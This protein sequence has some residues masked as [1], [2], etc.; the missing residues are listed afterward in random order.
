MCHVTVQHFG[1]LGKQKTDDHRILQ[2]TTN[3]LTSLGPT[4]INAPTPHHHPTIHF[5][6]PAAEEQLLIQLWFGS[7]NPG[8]LRT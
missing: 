6:Y 8:A 2:P 7:I 4:F 3:T 5:P 1:R